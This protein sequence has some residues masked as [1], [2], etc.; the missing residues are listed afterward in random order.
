MN[1]SII[2]EAPKSFWPLIIITDFWKET[3]WCSIIY[4]AVIASIDQSLYE[5]IEI[6]GGGR[7]AKALYITWP[8]LKGNLY[9]AFHP[10]L[11]QYHVRRREYLRTV[12][13]DG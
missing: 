6:D 8:S 7:F 12:L 11:R 5:A 9:G 3:G 4:L 10:Y 2:W 13:C 1:L